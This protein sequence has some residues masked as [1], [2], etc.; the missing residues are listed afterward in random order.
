MQLTDNV[1]PSNCFC[2]KRSSC[3]HSCF[4]SVKFIVIVSVAL[5]LL[6]LCCLLMA[7]SLL[8]VAKLNHEGSW[9][10]DDRCACWGKLIFLKHM[11]DDVSRWH[12]RDVSRWHHRDVSRWHQLCACL[13][14]QKTGFCVM[15]TFF[16]G[17]ALIIPLKFRV[18]CYSLSWDRI[19][20]CL[21]YKSVCTYGTS[22]TTIV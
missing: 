17:T 22:I 11:F 2:A 19:L 6:I 3:Y 14:Y 21:L 10:E 20:Y 4:C 5:R 7:S 12:H 8:V 13:C 1:L 9:V 15:D 18:L 16:F